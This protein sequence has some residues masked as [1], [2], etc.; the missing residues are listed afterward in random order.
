MAERRSI[1]CFDID[2]VLIDSREIVNRSYK[3]VG[4]DMPESAWGHPWNTWLPTIVGSYDAAVD[5]HDRKTAIYTDMLKEDGIVARYELPFASI[6]RALE[7]D[8]YTDVYYVT[9]AS[10]RAATTIVDELGLTSK[11]ILGSGVTTADRKIVLKTLGDRGVY[12]D[13][14][15][16]GQVPAMA[17]GWGFIWARQDWPSWRQ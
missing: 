8:A 2:G 14:R 4:V 7:R 3:R 17:A 10:Q 15:I 1:W 9:G 11:N 12:V 16:E 5:V 13:D 6:A